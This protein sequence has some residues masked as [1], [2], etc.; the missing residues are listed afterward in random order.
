MGQ[1]PSAWNALPPLLHLANSYSSFETQ[2]ER[3]LLQEAFPD[4]PGCRTLVPLCSPVSCAP[5]FLSQQL[6]CVQSVAVTFRVCRPQQTV[7]SLR[8]GTSVM[9]LSVLGATPAWPRVGVQSVW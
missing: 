9:C 7:S 3:H 8:A 4:F 6:M 1:V 5:L 2:L